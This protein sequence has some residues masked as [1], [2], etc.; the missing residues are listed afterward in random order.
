MKTAEHNKVKQID[1]E[2]WLYR[3]CFIQKFE[4]PKLCG[5]YSVFKNNEEQTD[6]NRCHTFLEAKKLA[7]ENECF[8]NFLAF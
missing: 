6:I 1:T 3:G 2:E 7:K 5:K 8:D 4:H